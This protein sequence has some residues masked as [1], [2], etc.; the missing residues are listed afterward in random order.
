MSA[1]IPF[2]PRT[3]AESGV[4]VN[5]IYLAELG[6]CFLILLTVTGMV[7]TFC[8]RYRRG[9][10]ASRAGLAQKAWHFEIGWTVATL[11]AFLA[12]F[13]WGAA[14]FL[15][16]YKLPQGDI[17]IFV[18]GKQWMWYIQHPG[19]QREIDALHIPVGKTI[20]LVLASQDVIHSFFIPAF[21][22]KRDAVPGTYETLWLRASEAGEYR[23]ECSEFC[24]TQHSRM[25]GKVVVM[26]LADY[27]R[28]LALQGVHE[29]LVAQGERLFRSYGCSG[30]HER[31]ST[32]RA[33]LLAGLYGRLV[34]L[35]DGS[36]VRADERYIRDAILLPNKEIAAGY[37]PVMPSF[38]GQVGED[39][40]LRL[41][42]YI[43]SLSRQDR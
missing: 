36:T 2:W 14:M 7:V 3:A 37:P 42:A 40:M 28:W 29:S 31:G 23:L 21:R 1:W 22:L 32:V 27:A 43:Q 18:V 5:D 25:T 35:Q 8:I 4:A 16:L 13:V 26:E 15:W 11:V 12:L 24:G 19:G 34:H 20:R 9:S 10:A 41:I 39:D 17:E 38:Q 6:V 33:P 30:C